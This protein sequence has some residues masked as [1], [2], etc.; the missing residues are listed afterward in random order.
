[1]AWNAEHLATSLRHEHMAKKTE[2]Q[3]QRRIRLD[4]LMDGMGNNPGVANSRTI[5]HF[6]NNMSMFQISPKSGPNLLPMMVNRD[7]RN[8]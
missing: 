6:D 8:S 7:K 2:A 4:G 1:M 5:D 3:V